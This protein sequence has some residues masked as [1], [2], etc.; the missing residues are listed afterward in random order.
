MRAI[1]CALLCIPTA[2]LAQQEPDT[3]VISMDVSR[4]ALFATVREGKARFISDLEQKHFT[5]LEDGVAQKI[6]SFSREDVPVAIGLLV[7]NSQSMM[8][9]RAEV[10]AAAK[11]FV[12]ASKPQDEMFVIHF[13]DKL[14]YGLPQ[15]LPFTGDRDLLGA[16]LDKM[17][18][19]GK[20]ALY[21]AIHEGL[22]HLGNSKLTKK[23]LI[24]LSDGGDNMSV[25]K[26]EGVVKEADLSGALFYGIGIYDPMDG[27][28][29]P[30]VLRKL[31]QNTGGEAY[32]PKELADVKG[33]CETIAR[34]LRN[35]YLLSYAPQQRSTGSDYHRI[36]VKVKD[37]QNRK[38][39]IRTRTGYFESGRSGEKAPK[40]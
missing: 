34:D 35:Q 20:T 24:V 29:N 39:I 16:A 33:L 10:V 19:D 14:T 15:T 36:Q 32:F 8:N 28:A 27:D 26:A 18:L 2:L 17:N 23:A 4:V 3:P 38:L 5:V 7:D 9:K 37:P 12:A 31:A 40:R 11:A 25:N 30:G 1:L 13:N 6:L 21:D 22:K